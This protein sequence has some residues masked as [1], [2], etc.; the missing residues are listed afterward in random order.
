MGCPDGTAPLRNTGN[1]E[2]DP[3][4]EQDSDAVEASAE[5]DRM[6]DETEYISENRAQREQRLFISA[7]STNVENLFSNT[8]GIPFDDLIQNL[9]E[10]F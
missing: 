6:R 5:I 7:T 1:T 4:V 9:L 3:I 10:I 8:P 2:E